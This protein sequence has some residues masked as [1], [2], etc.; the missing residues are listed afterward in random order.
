MQSAA[1]DWRLPSA[2]LGIGA[3]AAWRAPWGWAAADWAVATAE[4]RA[5]VAGATAAAAR[6]REAAVGRRRRQPLA[7]SVPGATTGLG[8]SQTKLGCRAVH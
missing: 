7:T 2:G 4:M 6:S 5:Q 8:D 3:P 1:E